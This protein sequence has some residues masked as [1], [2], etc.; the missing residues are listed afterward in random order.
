MK[1]LTYLINTNAFKYTIITIISYITTIG[2]YIQYDMPNVTNPSM[3]SQGMYD[4]TFLIVSIGI[5]ILIHKA[6]LIINKRIAVFSTIT[7]FI[8]SIFQLLGNIGNEFSNY[9]TIPETV[10]YLSYSLYKLFS[11]FIIFSSILVLLF[12]YTP[13]L[14]NKIAKSKTKE[15]SFFT[16]NKKSFWVIALVFFISYIPFFLNYYPGIIQADT[17][18]MLDYFHGLRTFTSHHSVFYTLLINL[19]YYLGTVINNVNL[20]MALFTIIQMI[21][22]SF[23]FSYIFY[24]LAK[25]KITFKLRVIIFLF[26][27]LNPLIGFYVIRLEKSWPFHL[28]LILLILYLIDYIKDQTSFTTSIKKSIYWGLIIFFTLLFR[29]NS[30]YIIL[31]TWLFLFI[32]SKNKKYILVLFIIPIVLFSL[33]KGIIMYCFNIEKG[34]IAEM[35]SIPS[36]Q[37]ARI[38]K[39]EYDS[40]SQDEVDLIEKY[41]SLS[42][43]ELAEEYNPYMS[44]PIKEVLDVDYLG[45]NIL[46]YFKLSFELFIKHPLQSMQAFIYNTY[47][48]YT[49]QS[50]FESGLTNFTKEID[51]FYNNWNLTK[52]YGVT[53]N[54]IIKLNIFEDINKLLTFHNFPIISI[55][56]TSIGFYVW[57]NI[58]LI[59]YYLYIKKYKEI[60]MFL[61]ILF[62]ILT[63]VAGPI[64]D[65]RY[66]FS[67]FIITPVYIA[68][69]LNQSKKALS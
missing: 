54:P 61:P 59:M 5:F 20:S 21:L 25:N 30:I 27:F 12:Y 65:L 19:F 10:N 44:D 4:I 1:K 33:S 50:H 69:I 24:Y 6:S 28:G 41:Y 47:G 23:V 31:L 57:I 40:L 36:Q 37:I 14:S 62:N 34:R 35:L 55:I 45:D 17:I 16:N 2:L 64:V 58:Y 42:A 51:T 7:G 66:V 3:Y 56:F 53:S 15:Y 46:D 8:F 13:K 49:V 60:I 9:G 63:C 48:Y 11:F 26:L 32:I 43:K 67:I 22:S 39:Y 29:N 18:V 68:F 52:N 38:A